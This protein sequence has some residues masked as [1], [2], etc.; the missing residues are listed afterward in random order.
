MMIRAWGLRFLFPAFLIYST[1]VAV[2]VA[3]AQGVSAPV[4][5]QC[6]GVSI[7]QLADKARAARTRTQLKGKLSVLPGGGVATVDIPKVVKGNSVYCAKFVEGNSYVRVVTAI[8]GAGQETALTLELPNVGFGWQKEMELVLV[9][10]PVDKKGQLNLASPGVSVAQKVQV[11]DFWFSL[12]CAVIVVGLAYLLAGLSLGR[13]N[14]SYSWNPVYLTSGP[15][16]KASLSQFQV[17][18]FTLLVLGVLVFVLL[19][20]SVFSDISS[21]ILLLLGISAGGAAGSKVAGVTK[22]RLSFENWSWLRNQGWLRTYQVGLGESPD[23][24][25]ARWGDLL[26]TEGSFDIYRFQLATFSLLVGLAILTSDLNALAT[27]TL[28]PNILALLGLSN[29]V[30][31]AGKAVTPSSIGELDQK[32]RALRDAE[33]DWISQVITATTPLSDQPAKRQTAM[34]TAPDKYQS[35]IMFARETARMLKSL[36]GAAGTKFTAEPITDDELMPA[37]P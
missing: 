26:K 29:V 5:K 7:Q 36:Y 20:T 9:S 18:A 22:K 23:P 33:K 6:Q 2:D 30:Y 19:R 3:Y 27:F 35:Y 15:F 4:Q 13:V 16:G 8:S 37:F 10:F 11:S 14:K 12:V 21:D 1:Y 24:R 25:R 17:F 31:I 34:K 28:P 32:V